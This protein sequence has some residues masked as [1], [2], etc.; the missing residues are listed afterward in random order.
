[1]TKEKKE[2]KVAPR[3]VPD[4]DSK[5]MGLAWF[6]AAFSKDPNTQVGA[7]IVDQYNTPMG[8]GYNGPPASIN[9]NDFSW[10]RPNKNTVDEFSKYDVIIHAEQNAIRRSMGDLRNAVL[11]VTGYPCKRCMLEIAESKIGRVVYMDYRSDKKSILQNTGDRAVSE[12]IARLAHI[13]L[14]KFT[15]NVVWVADWVE[16]MRAIGVFGVE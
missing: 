12:E 7:Q 9:D 2:K 15:G 14:E 3:I 5:Y 13:R 8:S 1:M 16:K 4:R 10:D 11:Y 6:H